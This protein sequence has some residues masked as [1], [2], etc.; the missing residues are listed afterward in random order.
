[1]NS[2]VQKTVCSKYKEFLN[3]KMAKI[4]KAQALETWLKARV[5]EARNEYKACE[6]DKALEI[7]N[8]ALGKARCKKHIESIKNKI[9]IAQ[10]A[11]AHESK[12]LALFEK[13][14]GLYKKGE[15]KDA[16]AVLEEARGHTK[17]KK[18]IDSLGE[19]IAKVKGK[20]KPV[21]QEQAN[22]ECN[23]I[24]PGTGYVA[25]N[26]RE[27]GSFDCMPSQQTA[28]ARCNEINKGFGWV[29][30]NIRTDGTFDCIR[31][32]EELVAQ[33]DCSHCGD[34][35]AVEAYWDEEEQKP[36]CRC[37]DGY[38]M[39]KNKCKPTKESVENRI[40]CSSVPNTYAGW[41][42]DNNRPASFCI[43]TFVPS[44]DG[45]GCVP[46]SGVA[47]EGTGAQEQRC[48]FGVRADGSCKTI[49]DIMDVDSI[50]KSIPK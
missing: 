4:R 22:A 9:K 5:D 39:I 17:C 43:D 42:E 2:A 27:D 28:N 24:N 8:T 33:A 47:T 7:L 44:S 6:Y 25:T 35:G 20:R 31:T 13:A 12:T 15:F 46:Q 21:T 16:L 11:K 36:M 49:G 37:K 14:K 45:S 32:K 10:K 23:R 40:D 29:A 3:K 18:Y 19:K 50:K 26:L 1:L 48:D 38:V 41:D 30:K 34:S